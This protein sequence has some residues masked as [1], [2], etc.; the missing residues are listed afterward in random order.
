MG[1]IPDLHFVRQML[2]GVSDRGHLPPGRDSR[3]D[4]ER[5]HPTGVHHDRPG[6][7]AMAHLKL[8]TTWLGGCSGCHMSFLDLD[9]WLLEL[10]AQADLVYSPFLDT[11]EFPEGV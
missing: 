11:K 5:P 8:A 10:A 6:E 9:E 7:E 2:A 1:R 3:R 4:G